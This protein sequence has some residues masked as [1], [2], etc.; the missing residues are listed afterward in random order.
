M[1]K[2]WRVRMSPPP[3]LFPGKHFSALSSV[4]ASHRRAT[5]HEGQRTTWSHCWIQAGCQKE[6]QFMKRN[7]VV[8][9]GEP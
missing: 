7:C 4:L 6:I 9:I 3:V 1:E 2:V 8:F 5:D